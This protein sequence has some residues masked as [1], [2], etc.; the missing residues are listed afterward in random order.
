[1]KKTLIVA[2]ILGAVIVLGRGVP[3]LPAVQDVVLD[4]GAALIAERGA[5]AFP[6]SASL[7]VYVCGSASPLGMGTPKVLLLSRCLS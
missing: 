5:A 3:T 2:V 1:M 7:R 6:Q 4:R